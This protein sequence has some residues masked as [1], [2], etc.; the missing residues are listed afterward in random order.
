VAGLHPALDVDA[1]DVPVRES[2]AATAAAIG[3]A[4]GEAVYCGYSMGGRL[5]LRLALDRPELV[6]RLVL[7]S[8]TAGLERHDDREVRVGADEELAASVE[9]DGVE[10]FLERWLAQPLFAGVPPDAAGLADRRRLTPDYLA[11]CLRVLGTGTM[12]PM[13]PQLRRV[14]VPVTIVT[15]TADVKFTELGRRMAEAL[16]VSEHV[17]LEC[18]HAVPLEAPDALAEVLNEHRS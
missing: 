17:E 18:G 3:E 9:R 11:H 6:T 8:A 4:G 1:V 14:D 5:C 12:G 2:F 10:V 7:V 13:W 16:P 15:G